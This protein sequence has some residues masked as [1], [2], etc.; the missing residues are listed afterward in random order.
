MDHR[1]NQIHPERLLTLL[2]YPEGVD[3]IMS[4]QLKLIDLS[5]DD[6][7]DWEP[8]IPS[9]ALEATLKVLRTFRKLFIKEGYLEHDLLFGRAQSLIM[10]GARVANERVSSNLSGIIQD[11]SSTTSPPTEQRPDDKPTADGSWG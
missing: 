2:T 5:R 11:A 8:G 6:V 10:A 7:Y 3:R 9:E 4:G 1:T